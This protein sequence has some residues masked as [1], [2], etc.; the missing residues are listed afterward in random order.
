V[1]DFPIPTNLAESMRTGPPERQGWL[2]RLPVTVAALS[3]RWSVRTG[4]PY[5]PGGSASWV[6]PAVDDRGRPLVLKVAWT[7]DEA[8]HEPDGLR[9]WNGHGAVFLHD[10]LVDGPTT[11]LLL[12]RCEPGTTLG[13]ARSEPE[14]D[15]VLAKILTRLW[16]ATSQGP[17]RSLDSMCAGWADAFERDL[18]T[19]SGYDLD[20]G[21]VRAGVELFRNLPRTADRT[22]LL[23]TDLHA[24]NV[25]A[26]T[27]LPWLLIDPKPYLGD[28]TYDALQHLLNRDLR[29]DPLTVVHRMARLLELDPDRLRQWFFARCVVESVDAPRLRRVAAAIRPD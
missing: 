15:E 4:A 6:A 26:A 23:A 9:A 21:L 3:R 8:R 22:V 17:F 10:H 29:P 27:R 5:Q 28:P 25:L 13:S 19:A 18:Q 11:A 16:Q 14:Q 12:E 2:A 1:I 24:G 7:H 20:P